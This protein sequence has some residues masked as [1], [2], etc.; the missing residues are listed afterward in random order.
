ME[1]SLEESEFLGKEKISKILLKLAP[2]VM[3]G[4]L[5]SALYNIVDSLFVG[6]L[7]NDGLTALGV[8]YPLQWVIMALSVGTGVGVNAYMD[9]NLLREKLKKLIKQPG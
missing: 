6:R 1:K 7:S 2:P 4:Q 5:I 8:I 9:H 3:L